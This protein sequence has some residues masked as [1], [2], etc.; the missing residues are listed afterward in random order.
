MNKKAT[1]PL[2]LEQTM[3]TYRCSCG[4]EFSVSQTDGGRCPQCKKK[5]SGNALQHDLA[6]TMTLSTLSD[7]RLAST[8]V[9]K[10]QS[11]LSQES[12]IGRS[13]GHFEIVEPLG[14]GG[15]GYVYRALDKSLQRYVAVKV[16]Q[17]FSEDIDS[18]SKSQELDLLLQ[19]AVAQARVSH[20]NIVT[21][22][23]VGKDGDEPFLAMELVSG[24]TISERIEEGEVGFGEIVQIGLQLT[25]ALE[26]SFELD[27]IHGDI[28]PSNVMIQQNGVVKL[29]DFGMARRVSQQSSAAI[30]GTPNYLAPE[31]FDG[32]TPSIQSDMYA[33]GVM[34]YELTFGRLPV[35]L[36][37]RSVDAWIQSHRESVVEFPSLWPDHI[38]ERWRSI[39]ERLLAKDPKDRF[40]SYSELKSE[41][42]L[43]QP[44][45]SLSAGRMQ[46]LIAAA[47]DMLTV[48]L[49]MIPLRSVM[50]G[51]IGGFS[52]RLENF[53]DNHPLL[54]FMF[55][56]LDII[57]I[58]VYT[59]TVFFWR[60]SIGRALMY[61][62]VVNR[63]GLKPYRSRMAFRSVLRMSLVWTLV[64][65]FWTNGFVDSVGFQLA[66]VPLLG[67]VSFWIANVMFLLLSPNA[68][69]IQDNVFKTRVV[70]DTK[71]VE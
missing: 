62:R 12:D 23:Y 24:E 18:N 9:E 2:N 17:R 34:L 52:I 43:V 3:V 54:Y 71:E 66:F 37:G 65:G 49:F 67:L 28:K 64:L 44:T 46:R 21:I 36:S 60:H 48:I 69:S 22:Y 30:G 57:P 10:N 59:A 27:I 41:L 63:Y 14:S 42:K 53:L 70:L 19:E 56:F 16:L 55:Y 47:I 1:Q 25:R 8:R 39:L 61:V 7:E 33:M 20:P 29:S 5:V 51:E 58:A 11:N 32:D 68:R 4:N 31:I 38:P 50:S 13:L 6:M 26:F 40:P 35:K 45:K 15:Q